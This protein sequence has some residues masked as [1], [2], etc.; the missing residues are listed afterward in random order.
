MKT[1]LSQILSII[2]VTTFS[3][4]TSRSPVELKNQGTALAQQLGPNSE[5]LKFVSDGNF[6]PAKWASDY[7]QFTPDTRGM[8]A[9]TENS[10]LWRDG[11]GAAAEQNPYQ[12]I[13]LDSIEGVSYHQGYL[14]IKFSEQIHVLRPTLG[15]PF[16]NTAN[17]TAR[18]FKLLRNYNVPELVLEN[19]FRPHSRRPVRFERR[20]HSDYDN[21][22]ESYY[23]QTF[24]EKAHVSNGN[25]NFVL[26]T[27]THR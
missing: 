11:F 2:V 27:V 5:E 15:N 14:Q 3:G 9:L 24:T 18:L 17:H 12:D 25:V 10:L 22:S 20:C 1:T 26:G 4:C 16:K 21:A 7:Y 13:R 19:A 6:I 8:I 23:A